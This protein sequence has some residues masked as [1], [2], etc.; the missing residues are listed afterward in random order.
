MLTRLK[1]LMQSEKYIYFFFWLNSSEYFILGQ[2]ESYVLSTQKKYIQKSLLKGLM[3]YFFFIQIKENIEI[4]S[5]FKLK[6][7]NI[8]YQKCLRH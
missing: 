3:S 2:M 4:K 7:Q 6:N 5:S 1:F 8:P